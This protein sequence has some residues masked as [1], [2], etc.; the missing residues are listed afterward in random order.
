[1]S[2]I[3]ITGFELPKRTDIEGAARRV[4]ELLTASRRLVPNEAPQERRQRLARAEAEYPKASAALSQMLLGP[5]ASQLG[6]KRLLIVSEGV[7]QYVPFAALPVPRS[8][9]PEVP[10]PDRPSGGCLSNRLSTPA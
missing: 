1:M 3:S 8:V 4:Y 9:M 7:L 5:V 10:V 6:N 2:P